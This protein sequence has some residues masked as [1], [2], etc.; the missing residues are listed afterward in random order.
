[1]K[2]GNGTGGISKR[3]KVW[4]I[5]VSVET[6]TGRQQLTKTV[7]GTKRDAE[8]ELARLR[9]ENVGNLSGSADTTIR[10]L[11]AMWMQD[12][13]L[14]AT[15]RDQYERVIRSLPQSFTA[16]K[17]WRLRPLEVQRLYRQLA[18]DGAS[19][20]AIR[21]VH[22][23]L[24]RA[25][26]LGVRWEIVP[27]NPVVDAS[28]PSVSRP[29]IVPPD[30]EGVDRLVNAADGDM[31]TWLI[32]S[33]T[34]GARRGEVAGLQWGDIDWNNGA[35]KF[36]RAIAYTP[37]AG[38]HPKETKTGRVK[39]VSIDAGTVA[40]LK[41]HRRICVERALSAGVALPA[42]AYVFSPSLD[43]EKP[44]RPDLATKRFARLRAELGLENVRLHDLRHSVATRLLAAGTDPVTVSKRLGHARVST[45]LDIYAAWV[46]ANDRKAADLLAVT[47]PG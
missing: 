6:P 15:T 26:K 45:T 3:G 10:D 21:R 41:D 43:G 23:A 38:V 4:R 33:A 12:A 1:M 13:D 14:A 24:R 34:T 17:A 36:H 46:P 40:A 22:N 27:R 44:W 32:V 7:R 18:D 9:V 28:P 2:R 47:R 35:I 5:S 30:K 31:L 39:V 20:H 29:D 19:P 42:K 16:M 11:L 37:A 8:D 25:Y